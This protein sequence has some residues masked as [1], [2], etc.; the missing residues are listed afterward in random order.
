MM[1]PSNQ[2]HLL[3]RLPEIV[4]A[5]NLGSRAPEAGTLRF[6]FFW[7]DAPWTLAVASPKTCCR[8]GPPP[9]STVRPK[10]A[11][12]TPQNAPKTPKNAQNIAEKNAERPTPR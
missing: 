6:R 9:E 5:P 10:N 11:P 3:H 8:E 7:S 12:K 1:H 4:L 2:T